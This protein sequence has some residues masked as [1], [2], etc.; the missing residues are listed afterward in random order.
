M[1]LTRLVVGVDF[2][3]SSEVAV[4]RAAEIAA[5]QGAELVLVHAGTVV[6]PP[7]VP[8]SMQVARDAYLGVLRAQLA[9]DRTR[10][11][12]LRE[13]LKAT[14]IEVS[15]LVVD[16]F[17]DDALVEAATELHAEL[18]VTGARPRGHAAR[19]LLGGVAAKV[20][21]AAEQSVLCARPGDPDR[22]F[23]RIVVGTDFSE[24]ARRALA[25]AIDVAEPGAHVAV[26]HALELGWSFT[27]SPDEL[28]AGDP[29]L[30]AELHADIAA[31]GEALLAPLRGGRVELSFTSADLRPRELLRSEAERRQADLVVVGGF[32]HRGF[33]RW[34]LGSVAED[35]VS[36][37]PCSVLVAR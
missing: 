31:R 23:S 1:A 3:P 37:A 33:R 30:R 10:L 8:A 13:R 2:S 26:V 32:G 6:E 15:Q 19:W 11:A 4:A 22:G 28:V 18:I 5:H 16:R 21:R 27:A 17:P 20:V 9:Q 25:R 14:G 7:E 34:L 36:D 12:E 24:G 29:A 35:L